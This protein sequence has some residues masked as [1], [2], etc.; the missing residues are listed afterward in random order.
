MFTYIAIDL[1]GDRKCYFGSTTNFE[2]RQSQH[3]KSK[4]S[5][6]FQNALKQRQFFWV[7][8][9]NDGLEDRSEEQY[10]LDFYFDS[11]WCFNLTNNATSPPRAPA[12]LPDYW[13]EAIRKSR[14]GQSNSPESYERGWETRRENGNDHHTFETRQRMVQSHTGREHSAESKLKRSIALKGK[15]SSAGGSNWYVNVETEKTKMAHSHPGKG[16]IP[17]RT[18]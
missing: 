11:P 18:I 2:K 14:R 3:L 6:P 16:W 15:P 1:Y 10:Y 8:S 13:V 9:E 12:I 7:C 5:Y 17:G 4:D